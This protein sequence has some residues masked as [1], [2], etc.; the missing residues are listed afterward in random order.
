MKKKYI[1]L[2]YLTPWMIGILFFVVYPF[3]MSLFYSFTDYSM[4]TEPKFIGFDNYIKM[5]TDDPI[6]WSS[7]KATIKFVFLT[8]PFKLIFAL[9]VAYVM[10]AKLKGIG[11]FRTAYYIPSILGANVAIAVLWQ[12]LFKNDGLVNMV[13]NSIGL[14]NVAWFSSGTGAMLTIVLLRVWQFGSAMVIFLNALTEMPQ[15]LYEAAAIDGASK[16]RQFFSVTLPQLTPIIFFNLILQLVQ[17]FQEFDGPFLI[18]GGGPMRSTYLLP[19]YIYDN[20]FKIFN[21]GYSSA[22]SWVLFV[23]IMIFTAILFKTSKNW[24]FYADGRG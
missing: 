5:F 9:F 8:V 1:G 15:D 12:F 21:M 16:F 23:M 6:F 22:L 10:N 11:F 20:A 13:L 7:V 17:A 4:L 24:V 14:A 2:L 19:M 18:T 3:A